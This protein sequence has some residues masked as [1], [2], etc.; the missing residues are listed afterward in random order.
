LAHDVADR[1][2]HGRVEENASGLQSG[3]IHAHSLSRL[4][5]SHNSPRIKLCSCFPPIANQL[6]VGF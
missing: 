4:K 3:K 2:G 5:G 6:V 1:G